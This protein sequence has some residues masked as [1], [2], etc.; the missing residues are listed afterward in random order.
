MC[1]S[2]RDRAHFGWVGK[3]TGRNMCEARAS[4]E[5]EMTVTLHD[6]DFAEVGLQL[7]CRRCGEITTIPYGTIGNLEQGIKFAKAQRRRA[8][9]NK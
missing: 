3:S 2:P 8:K 6:A 9:R 5:S 1:R 7:E 4:L